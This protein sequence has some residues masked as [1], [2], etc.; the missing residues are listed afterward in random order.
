MSI[1]TV[2]GGTLSPLGLTLM[3]FRVLIVAA[4]VIYFAFSLVVVRQVYLMTETLTTNDAPLMRAFS[5]IHAGFALGLTL[6]F[7]GFML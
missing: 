4:A 3:V 7:V 2:A 1:E 6:L 5:I